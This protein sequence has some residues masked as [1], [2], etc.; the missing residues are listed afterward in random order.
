M[1][2]A[3][4]SLPCLLNNRV[5][6]GVLALRRHNP[7][8]D[9]WG[10]GLETSNEDRV[11]YLVDYTEFE[12]RAIVRPLPWLEAGSRFGHLDGTIGRGTDTR[13]PSIQDRFTNATAP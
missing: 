6:V 4:F 10:V 13:F 1:L 11:N 8:E 9:Y 2:Q 3:D 12:G 7:Q 5:E